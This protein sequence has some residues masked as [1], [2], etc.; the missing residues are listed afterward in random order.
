MRVRE[1]YAIAYTL[2]LFT[3]ILCVLLDNV[4]VIAYLTDVNNSRIGH[5]R[6]DRRMS[7]LDKTTVKHQRIVQALMAG[8]AAA[9]EF[10]EVDDG[11]TCNFDSPAIRF[12]MMREDMLTE[13]AEMAGVRL[14]KFTWFGKTWYW[15][16]LQW[17]GQGNRRTQM[18]EAA[19]KAIKEVIG[20][21]SWAE[22]SMYYQMD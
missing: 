22:V 21:E 2:H 19:C 17:S 7:V 18:A 5:E 12:P 9:E 16:V 14:S 8:K 6:K 13:L 3:D 10:K 20:Q 11:G 15:V 4:Y 1:K